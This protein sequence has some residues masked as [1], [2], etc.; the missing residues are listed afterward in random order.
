MS[1]PLLDLLLRRFHQDPPSPGKDCSEIAEDF[2][3]I[4]PGRVLR[5]TPVN[6]E[7]MVLP[8]YEVKTDARYHAVYVNGG[9]VFDPRYSASPVPEARYGKMVAE[10]NP[11]IGI[12][13]Q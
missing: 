10:M 8:E 1:D 5:A 2:A 7:R 6:A 4:V 3:A 13:W 11:G 12:D 9:K